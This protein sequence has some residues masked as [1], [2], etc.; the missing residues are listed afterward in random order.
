MTTEKK[1]KKMEVINNFGL[2]QRVINPT[3]YI[4]TK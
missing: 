3:G 1:D 2:Q 4:L